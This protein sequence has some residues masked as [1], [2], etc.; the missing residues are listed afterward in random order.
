MPPARGGKSLVTSSTL[1]TRRPYGRRAPQFRKATFGPRGDLEV[2]FLNLRR[3][4]DRSDAPG[5]R[6]VRLVDVGV[7][8]DVAGLRSVEHLAVADVDADVADRAVEEEQVADL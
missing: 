3:G 6:E 1:G 4:A 2:A 8:H 7:L 5:G